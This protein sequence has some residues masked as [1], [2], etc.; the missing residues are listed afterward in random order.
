M[1]LGI[2][3][4][5]IYLAVFLLFT[6]SAGGQTGKSV[7]YQFNGN[8]QKN[9]VTNGNQSLII[10]YS[11]SEFSIDNIVNDHGSFYRISIPG[12]TPTSIAGKPELPVYSRLITIPDGAECKV[13][14]SEVT[15][16]RINPSKEKITGIL[17]PRQESETKTVQQNKPAF[18]KDKVVY[19]TRGIINSDTV[20]IESIG[21]VRNKRLASVHIFPIRYNPKSNVLEVITSMKIEITFTYSDK[22]SSKSLLPETKLFNESLGKGVLNYNSSDL[23]PGYTNQPVQMVIITDTA[24]KKQLEPFIRWKTQKG[25]KLRVLYKG[26]GLA[27]NT[28]IQ[29]KDTLTKIYNAATLTDPAPEYL[30]IIGDVNRVPYYGM[31]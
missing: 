7:K 21:T 25:Y 26:T 13:K 4:Q 15:S 3:K 12:H 16:T 2:N 23:I 29:L 22:I 28:Y 24:F 9:D 6:A 20:T 8:L 18:L 14:V 5:A 31:G 19:S 11:I 17:F 10:N 27:G 30:L 1:R